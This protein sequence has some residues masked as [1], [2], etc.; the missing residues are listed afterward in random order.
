MRNGRNGEMDPMGNGDAGRGP[1][2]TGLDVEWNGERFRLLPDRAMLWPD[3]NALLLCDLHLGKGA[4][5]RR[6]GIPVPDGGQQTTL[7]RIERLLER[8]RPARIVVLGDLFHSRLNP[9]W[10]AFV[11]WRARQAGNGEWVLVR[12]NHDILPGGAYLQAGIEV[13]P[14]WREGTIRMAHEPDGDC[15]T[16]CGHL[17]PGVRIG[18]GGRQKVVLSCFHLSP[19]R[20]ILPAFGELTGLHALRVG[21]GERAFA[22]AEDRIFQVGEG[23]RIL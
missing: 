5:L 6:S 16:L 17:H 3:R 1:E 15:P 22:L 19:G 2:G 10:G 21:R 11:D 18:L 13:V 14:E 20:L 8:H 9:E 4:H 12:G 23:N 7:E